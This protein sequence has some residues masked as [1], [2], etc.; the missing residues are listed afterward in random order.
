MVSGKN[1]A[2][3]PPTTVEALLNDDE[4]KEIKL[5]FYQFLDREMARENIL[6]YYK[7]NR[8][9]QLMKTGKATVQ[10]RHVLK[11]IKL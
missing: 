3:L 1:R 11:L 9:E 6:Y 5:V 10:V 2:V 4:Y 8:F 7:C